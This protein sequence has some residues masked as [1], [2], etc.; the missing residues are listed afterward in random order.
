MRGSSRARVLLLVGPKGSGKTTIG[1]MLEARP[2]VRFLEVEAIARRVLAEAGGAIDEAY[3][4]RALSAIAGV[5]H[6]VAGEHELIVIE[7]TGASQ[8]AA[9]FLEELRL[10]HDVT[11]VRVRAP[12][13]TCARRIAERD[14]TRQVPVDAELV[15]RMHAVTEALTWP[16]DVVLDNDPA[17]EP[18]AVERALGPWLP[19]PASSSE[20]SLPR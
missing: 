7:T 4:R 15:R 18:D 8:H 17:L 12:A 13:E 16:W 11:L 20:R 14:S 3:A 5:V 6:A 9:A 19:A 2:G 10:H 1:G